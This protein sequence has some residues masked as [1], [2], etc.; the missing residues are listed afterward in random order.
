MVDAAKLS[1]EVQDRLAKRSD[2]KARFAKA[3]I[4]LETIR[5]EVSS[6]DAQLIRAGHLNVVVACW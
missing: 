1:K 4:E 2:L 3:K 6:L 5:G